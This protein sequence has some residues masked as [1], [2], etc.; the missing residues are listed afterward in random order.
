MK[1][2]SLVMLVV[3]L[4]ALTGCGWL[5]KKEAPKPATTEQAAPAPMT[6]PAAT[7]ATTPA[8]TAPVTTP[9]ATPATPAETA[10]A[11]K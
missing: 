8:P 11:A 10:P 4:G 1:K 7:P 3:S 6:T 5:S 2:L 9:A